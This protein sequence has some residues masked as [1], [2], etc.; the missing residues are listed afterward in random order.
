MTVKMYTCNCLFSPLKKFFF[1]YNTYLMKFIEYMSRFTNYNEISQGEDISLKHLLSVKSITSKREKY[2][3]VS[4][5][6][7][8]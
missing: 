1:N 6:S 4:F 5:I 3:F 8:S 7:S 2:H